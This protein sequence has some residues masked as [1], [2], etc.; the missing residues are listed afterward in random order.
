[1]NTRITT[2]WRPALTLFVLLSLLT[3]LAYP[4]AVTAVAQAAFL[5]E[6]SDPL[7]AGAVKVHVGCVDQVSASIDI[8]VEQA[9]RGILVGTPAPVGAEGHRAQRQAADAQP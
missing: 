7:L 3:G 1:M 8:A 6:V 2:Q 9:A 5:D 4:L